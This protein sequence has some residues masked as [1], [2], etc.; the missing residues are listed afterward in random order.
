MKVNNQGEV[1]DLSNLK[2]P[3]TVE[4]VTY[5]PHFSIIKNGVKIARHFMGKKFYNFTYAQAK[6][7]ND[8]VKGEIFFNGLQIDDNPFLVKEC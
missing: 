4:G 3:V 5:T 7:Y 8:H 1:V 6:A 2:N